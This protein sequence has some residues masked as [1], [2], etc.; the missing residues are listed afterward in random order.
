MNVNDEP[1]K[2]GTKEEGT[3]AAVQPRWVEAAC[4]ER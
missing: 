3:A 1:E 4:R 2:D